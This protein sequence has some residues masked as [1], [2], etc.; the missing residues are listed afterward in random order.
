M[1][2]SAR[3]LQNTTELHS[4]RCVPQATFQHNNTHPDAFLGPFFPDASLRVQSR[5]RLATWFKAKKLGIPDLKYTYTYIKD[6]GN[7]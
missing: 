3:L 7:L 5:K 2:V 1:A 6:L 4:N